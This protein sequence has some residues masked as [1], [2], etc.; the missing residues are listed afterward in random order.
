MGICRFSGLTFIVGFGMISTAIGQSTGPA[1]SSGTGPI[2]RTSGVQPNLQRDG[3][4]QQ[5]A[6]RNAQPANHDQAGTNR[7][8]SPSTA[9][10]E[11]MSELLTG[12]YGGY[13]DGYMDG[14]EDAVYYIIDLHHQGQ[15][16]R[17]T[18]STPRDEQLRQHREALRDHMRSMQSPESNHWASADT[19]RISGQ[20]VDQWVARRSGQQHQFVEVETSRGKRCEVDLGSRGELGNLQVRQNDHITARGR[21][22][23]FNS[24]QPMFVA[25]RFWLNDNQGANANSSQDTAPQQ[26]HA[27]D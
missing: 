10:E 20:V 11:G 18:A 24:D 1:Q 16:A 13:G 17:A 6:A 7:G 23:D 9:Q 5:P 27:R 14:L 15:D 4:N 12:Y 25:Q 26:A 2:Q 19:R 22:H 21:F 8:Q 3:R